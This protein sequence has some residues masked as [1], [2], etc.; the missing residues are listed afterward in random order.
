[1][2]TNWLCLKHQSDTLVTNIRGRHDH[3]LTSFKPTRD[4]LARI[5]P[6]TAP[7]PTLDLAQVT[8]P[9]G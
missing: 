8:R 6:L 9:I 3:S 1:M 5:L 2:A 7:V 4:E